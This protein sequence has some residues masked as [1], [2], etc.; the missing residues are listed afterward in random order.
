MNSEDLRHPRIN[1]LYI[2]ERKQDA[3]ILYLKYTNLGAKVSLREVKNNNFTEQHLGKL[4][5]CDLTP[6]VK[7]IAVSL[8][9]SLHNIESVSPRYTEKHEG[10][11]FNFTIWILRKIKKTI[12]Q[13]SKGLVTIN[14]NVTVKPD[15]INS[16]MLGQPSVSK[17]K[18]SLIKCPK[19]HSF[20]RNDRLI[21][22]QKKV[23][24][25]KGKHPIS[26]SRSL[27][28][29]QSKLEEISSK[30][31]GKN[32]RGKD[33]R[34]LKRNIIPIKVIRVD[35]EVFEAQV[36]LFK[37]KQKQHNWGNF[38]V[39]RR[40]KSFSKKI[41][42]EN[43]GTNRCRHCNRRAILGEDVCYDCHIK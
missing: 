24:D 11:D 3:K 43:L 18:S 16:T 15:K 1:I 31:I 2:P 12:N 8:A 10:E 14:Q 32:N 27:S 26:T 28:K 38:M 5:Y 25:K 4:Y 17:E 39:F 13:T 20:V 7:E 23:H 40:K 36:K 33:R 22:H 34:R 9:R 21:K 29:S 37:Q 35:N 30:A 6:R 41:Q 42:T 19:C